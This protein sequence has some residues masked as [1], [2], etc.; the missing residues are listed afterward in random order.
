MTSETA[1]VPVHQ[2]HPGPG[3]TVLRL[4]RPHRRNALDAQTA[5]LLRAGLAGAARRRD[6]AV[7]ITGGD[8]FFSSGGDVESMPGPDG[9]VFGPAERLTLI[10]D[11]VLAMIG[12]DQVIIA[13]VERY[14]I[15]AAWGLVLACDLV[16]V[17]ENA[18]FKAPFA[19]RGMTAD[20][21]TAYHL[22][23]RL[24]QQRAAAH[25]FLGEPLTARDARTAG[26][27]T[28]T[29]APGSATSRAVELATTLAAGP[30]Q[31]NAITKSLLA[32]DRADLAQFLASERTAM[33]LAGHG[34]NARE[35]RNAFLERREPHF[36]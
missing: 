21:G 4:D 5:E 30:T 12:A 32:R 14:A 6:A 15:G 20:A 29:V 10:H 35:G 9:G 27:V 2:E 33:A 16:V 7:V 8:D 18:Y 26:L 19:A 28:E 3:V 22:P 11:L 24:G 23:R 1:Q 25:L 31:S 36:S 17:G 13:A 34:P